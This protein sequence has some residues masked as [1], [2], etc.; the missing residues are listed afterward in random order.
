MPYSQRTSRIRW[1]Q[2]Y[3][4]QVKFQIVNVNSWNLIIIETF[5]RNILFNE[6]NGGNIIFH[7]LTTTTVPTTRSTTIMSST[8]LSTSSTTTDFTTPNPQFTTMIITKNAPLEWEEKM[9]NARGCLLDYLAS[10]GKLQ[11]ISDLVQSAT[12]E[13]AVNLRTVEGTTVWTTAWTTA[14]TMV[15]E[16]VVPNIEPNQFNGFEYKKLRLV[17]LR[18]I[19][20]LL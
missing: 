15:G 8:T 17:I 3:R 11:S 6:C 2:F 4:F 16:R 5:T 7:D 20:Y 10:R 13:S 18:V 9:E 19:I 14:W 12:M 1:C